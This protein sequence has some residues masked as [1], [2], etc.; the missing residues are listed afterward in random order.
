MYG[1]NLRFQ[2]LTEWSCSLEL[3]FP[4]SQPVFHRVRTRCKNNPYQTT[5]IIFKPNKQYALPYLSPRR[6]PNHLQTPRNCKLAVTSVLHVPRHIR[7]G[8]RSSMGGA[9]V[10]RNGNVYYY[11]SDN[12]ATTNRMAIGVDVSEN[13]EGLY[14]EA[15]GEPLLENTQIDPTIFIDD[16]VDRIIIFAGLIFKQ[17]NVG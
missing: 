15:S 17:L 10:L 11:I 16:E 4:Y 3:G 6:P 9:G 13:I 14:V 1:Y 8:K 5:S 2:S 7:L 12:H